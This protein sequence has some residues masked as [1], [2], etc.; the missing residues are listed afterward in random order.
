MHD[1]TA[2]PP[3]SLAEL[4][5]ALR[6]FREERDWRK[7]HT[8]KNLAMS[9]AIEAGELMEHFQWLTN[10]EAETLAAEDPKARE[11]IG[12][13]LADVLMYCFHLADIMGLDILQI[14][15]AKLEKNRLRFPID[16]V[17]GHFT[18]KESS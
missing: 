7:Y 10:E 8:P 15:H 4:V 1:K 18:L 16:R 12:E 5:D 2:N 6:R 9:V 14:V 17:Q 11:E 13:E 3:R